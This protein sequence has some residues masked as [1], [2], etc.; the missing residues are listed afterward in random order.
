MLPL[1]LI[2]WSNFRKFSAT[3]LF[4]PL[5]LVLSGLCASIH[6]QQPRMRQTEQAPTHVV[7]AAVPFSAQRWADT[8]NVSTQPTRTIGPHFIGRYPGYADSKRLANAHALKSAAPALT[9]AQSPLTETLALPTTVVF[10]GPNESQTPFIPPDSVIAAGPNQVVVV[11]NSLMAI[12]DKSGVQQAPFQ[13]LS[14]FFSSLGFTGEIFDPRIIYDQQDNRF[15]LSAA[16]VDL[17]QFA[18]GHVFLAVSQ[19]S[20][21]TGGWNKY[22]IN[23]MGRDLSNTANTFPD[24]PGLGLSPTAVYLT[25]NQFALNADCLG[26]DPNSACAF[27]DAWIKVINLPELLSGSAT[28]NITTFQNVQSSSGQLAF[29]IQPAL[30]IGSPNAEFLVAASFQSNPGNALNLFSINLSGTLSLQEAD[31]SVAPFSLGPQAVQPGTNAVIDTGDFRTLNAVW[32]AGSLWVGHNVAGTSVFQNAARWYQ[33]QLAS[34]ATANLLQTGDI[35]GALAAYYPAIS[36]RADGLVGIAFTTSSDTIP[37]SAAFTVHLPADAAGVTD[38]YVIYRQGL[39]P[40]TEDRWGDYSGISEDPDGN[41]LWAIAEYAGQPSPHFGTAIT[42]ITSP[43]SVTVNPA[44]LSFGAVPLAHA[45]S[46]LTATFKN[47]GS[48]SIALGAATKTGANSGDFSISSDQCSGSTLNPGQSCAV[49]VV[50]T[51]S[52]QQQETAVVSYAYPLGQIGVGLIG[53]GVNIPVVGV[54]PVTLNFPGTPQNT[55]SAP[56]TVTLSNTGSANAQISLGA[57]P[58]PFT[59]TNN[60]PASLAP[61]ASC[62]VFVVFRPFDAVTYQVFWGIT[63]TTQGLLGLHI[64]GTGITAP[65]TVFCPPNLSF[66]NQQQGTASVPQPVILTNSGSAPIVITS[67]TTTGDF[68]QTNDCSGGFG[69]RKSCTIQVTFTPSVLGT[70]SGQLVLNDNASGSPQ[71]V[72]LSGTGALT[73]GLVP[74][75]ARSPADP[76]MLS[77]SAISTTGAEFALHNAQ[78]P[79]NFER[80]QGQFDP[81]IR[82]AARTLIGGVAIAPTK[83]ILQTKRQ[84]GLD[85]DA[86]GKSDS[87]HLAVSN[88]D[89]ELK[90]S[91]SE[92]NVSG[93]SKLR[94]TANY[95]IG[96]D[97]AGWVTNVPTF[98]VVKIAGV[99]PGIDAVFYGN[100]EKL[101]YDFIVSP[102]AEPRQIKLHFEGASHLSVAENG[103]LVVATPSDTYRFQRPV[104]YQVRP[105][106]SLGAN[107]RNFLD[108][109]WALTGKWD[110]AFVI[111]PFDSR[112]P[113]VIDPVLS[114]SSYLG[115]T[116]GDIANAIAVDSAGNIYVGGETFSTDF[117][118]NPNAIVKSCNQFNCDTGF[119]AKLSSDGSALLYSTYFGGKTFST[120]VKGIAVDATG[121]A[122]IAGGTETGDLPTTPGSLMPVCQVRPGLNS[123][124]NAFVA[125]LDPTGS[126]LMYSTY[127]GGTGTPIGTI[128]LPDAAT[129]IAVDAQGNA[130]VAGSAFSSDYPVTSGAFETTP[131]SRGTN[132]AFVTKLNPA[133]SALIFSTYLGG[134]L[135]DVA[136][137]VALDSSGNIVV[138]G[139]A[140]SIDFPTT[141]GA[142]QTGS[143]GADAFLAKFSGNG[144]IIFSTLLG[145][146]NDGGSGNHIAG[147]AND[148]KGY[149]YVAGKAVGSEFPTTPGSFNPGKQSFLSS[150]FVG[151]VHP[152]GCSLAYGT[153]LSSTSGPFSAGTGI[154]VDQQGDAFVTGLVTTDSLPTTLFKFVNPIQPQLGPNYGFIAELDPQGANLLFSSAMGGS[155][156][157]EPQAIALDPAANIY[158]AGLTRSLDLPIVLPSQP[159]CIGCPRLNS[160]STEGTMAFI[161][162]ILP[163][164]ASGVVLTRPS[165]SFQPEII[166]PVHPAIQALGLT[167]AQSVPLTIQ[168][169]AVAGAGY[170]L[171][172]SGSPC[173]GTIAPA[174][175]CVIEVQFAPTDG[176]QGAG[177]VTIADNG[178]GSPRVIPLTGSTLPQFLVQ[179]QLQTPNG[180]PFKGTPSVNYLVMTGTTPGST[181]SGTVQLSC[182]SNAA[183]S[184][185][186]N[187]VAVA[188]G[189]NSVLT[190][191]NIASGSTDLYS[192]TLVATLGSQVVNTP[193]QFTLADFSLTASPVAP[194]VSA[195]QTA[196]LNVTATGVNNISGIITFACSNLPQFAS[197]SFSPAT[198]TLNNTL[199]T[200]ASVNLSIS[201]VS[202]SRLP[203][204]QLPSFGPRTAPWILVAMACLLSVLALSSSRFRTRATITLTVI[205]LLGCISCGGGGGSTGGSS[206]NT[207]SSTPPNSHTT[208]PGTYPI[209]ITG[210]LGTLQRT[211][212][213]TL[214]VN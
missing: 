23:F 172:T 8:V 200:S 75:G 25:S 202:T 138:G 148:S 104:S 67:I 196:N 114:Y 174:G 66:A 84:T 93:L 185:S 144:T 76:P 80:N 78:R 162:K 60:C 106:G 96:S 132:H 155:M 83:L 182:A 110:A 27:S 39:A 62:Q 173:S 119:V 169:V 153:Y 207:G 171:A 16:E 170:S 41:S 97:S 72:A 92:A 91:N 69:P 54:S 118:T 99:Y 3:W 166:N 154:A 213:V 15:V 107:S 100:Q 214:T 19:T 175:T 44:E 86:I 212:Q 206:G 58:G 52:A 141:P 81:G 142:F 36:V 211:T 112:L 205:L 89:M 121:S 2:S 17:D 188:V 68:T 198:T 168:T 14:A 127:L 201:T 164:A 28:L 160:A 179:A 197:C 181:T 158:V 105:G 48:T 34:L 30:S 70:R 74:S 21:A 42:Q 145:A 194:I 199:V 149:S 40:Y 151:K 47:I 49:S 22:A 130:I 56:V 209:T 109:R 156:E 167:N 184:C 135:S 102:G 85:P 108:S 177:T 134:T 63:S 26:P 120:Q 136:N 35:S 178:P 146:G 176:G 7:R 193:L 87:R 90:D 71:I 125:K 139:D 5:S 159:T 210:S 6:A 129:S 163:G 147:L 88:L 137:A 161:A 183:V 103:D 11:I 31:L 117:P 45:S 140:Q 180:E 13:N 115:G 98:G 208:A 9:V 150:A 61:G 65:G 101:E 116:G 1:S 20:D 64:T 38:S 10:D 53:A 189:G 43:P 95:L 24:F 187:P 126:S 204:R 111:G 122:Y 131:P 32:S 77:G 18:N 157:D 55:P 51:P 191:G 195:G 33:I 82:F 79:L 133:G 152:S 113:L 128:A 190:V 165:M 94:G 203:M 29:S 4:V 192:F 37:A 123:C 124:P 59:E 73:T 46:P 143:Y 50:F 12:Y 57:I 186:F